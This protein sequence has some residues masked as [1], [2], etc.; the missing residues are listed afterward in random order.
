MRRMLDI[1]INDLR[2]LF[3]DPGIWINLVIIPIVISVAV[4]YANGAGNSGTP[5]NVILI[6]DVRDVDSS[7]DSA[8]F[9]QTVRDANANLILCPMDQNEDDICQL[10]EDQFSPEL[11][12][13]RL[14]NKVS[15]ALL[16]I[17]FG[18]GTSIDQGQAVNLIYGSNESATAPSYILQ[19]VQAAATQFGGAQV[20]SQVGMQIADS[21][22]FLQFEDEADRQAFADN[23]RQN[24]ESIWAT[25]PVS[26]VLVQGTASE[27]STSTGGGGFSQS[28]PGIAAMYIMFAVLPLTS[29]FILERKNWTLQRLAM[30]PISRS[31]IM[32][33]KL[34]ARFVLGIIQYGILMGFGVLVL[35]AS[36]GN[37]PLALLVVA[38]AYTICVTALALALTTFTTSDAQARGITLFLTLVLAPLG[39]AWW[40]LEIVPSLMR[41]IGHISPIAWFMDG[42]QQVIFYGGELGTVLIPVVVLLVMAAI[43]FLVGVFRFRFTN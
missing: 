24:A 16:E 28:I 6:V 39:G 35:G 23:I 8:R 13:Q 19:S 12:R 9:L 18:F 5:T 36:F 40:S 17:P 26:V 33:G 41:T 2:V 4:G 29:A 7:T 1:A 20:A 32:G 10:G 14:E 31:Q 30:M 37:A 38:V 27:G 43:L 25:N 22:E 21:V 42:H 34:L 15:L 3:K 11:A